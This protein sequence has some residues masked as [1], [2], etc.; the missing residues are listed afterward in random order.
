MNNICFC[1]YGYYIK[2]E[3]VNYCHGFKTTDLCLNKTRALVEQ[4][5][6]ITD[7]FLHL[8]VEKLGFC[9]DW[10]CGFFCLAK[11]PF[12][13]RCYEPTEFIHLEINCNHVTFSHLISGGG[14]PLSETSYLKTGDTWLHYCMCLFN[15]HT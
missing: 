12:Q 5:C 7:S 2:S 4:T 3:A 13:N 9:K 15:L 14:V 8:H 10:P 6:I 1:R 11:A